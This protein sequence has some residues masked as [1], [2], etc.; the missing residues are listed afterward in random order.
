MTLFSSH[1]PKDCLA[2]PPFNAVT[3]ISTSHAHLNNSRHAQFNCLEHYKEILNNKGS[4]RFAS[5]R[6]SKMHGNSEKNQS[7]KGK[8]SKKRLMRKMS[9]IVEMSVTLYPWECIFKTVFRKSIETIFKQ[10]LYRTKI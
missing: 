7:H 6:S 10:K 3:L 4:R 2:E 8:S 9:R 1:I 5:N